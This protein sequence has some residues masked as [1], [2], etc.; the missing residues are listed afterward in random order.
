[1]IKKTTPTHALL[2]VLRKTSLAILLLAYSSACASIKLPGV[3]T[4]PAPGLTRIALPTITQIS[5]KSTLPVET[6]TGTALPIS[7]TDTQ[8]P[9]AGLPH[10]L[11]N[12]SMDYESKTLDV[13][14]DIDYPNNSKTNIPDILLSVQ[15]NRIS[16]VFSL[17]ELRYNEQPVND[18]T[19]SGQSLRWKLASPFGPDQVAHIHIKYHL[20]LPLIEQSDPNLIRPQ[21]FGVTPRQVNLTDWYPMLVPFDAN[22]G[23]LLHNP[24]YY[25]E[26]LVYPLANF[27]VN[28]RFTDPANAPVIAASAKAEQISDGQH[29]LLEHGRD[30]VL[31]LGRQIKSIT[32]QVENVT[33]SSYY[34]AGNEKAGQAVLDAT[35]KAVETYST[36]FGPY[37]H[38]SLAAVQGDFND[39]MEFDGL[40]FLSNSFYNLYDNSEKN[41]LV[42]VAAHETSH[43]W[44]FGRVAS[45][46]NDQ[47]WLDEALATY[48][49]KLFYENNYPD[50]IGWWWSYRIDFY[51][52]DGKIDGSVPSYAGFTPYTNA[53]Y[54][55]GARFLDELRK[56]IGDETFFAFLKD[57][58]AQMDGKIAT[59]ADFFRILKEHT[60]ADLSTLFSKY[61]TTPAQ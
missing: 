22:N 51:Q 32:A 34:Y 6:A 47:P 2:R 5:P 12:A 41:Y 30:F 10:Y 16:G 29:Y 21:I 9:A 20:T 53:T 55:Q 46:Q 14:Q 4:I 40:Y 45:D 39:G 38:D 28:L 27:E 37:P 43:Q 24:W 57:Y 19:L 59:S 31:V 48:C 52:P 33:V 17:N 60:Q 42:M 7:P 13:E 35:V 58:A 18:Y 23:W 8:E 36:L 54:R 11:I 56:E 25:G 3:V 50:D 44:W 49:E 1:M 61:F 26:H 15:P